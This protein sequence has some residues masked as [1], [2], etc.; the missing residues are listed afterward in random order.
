MLADIQLRDIADP[1][2]GRLRRIELPI[3]EVGRHD[4]WLVKRPDT[5]LQH[6]LDRTGRRLP[7]RVITAARHVQQAAL[8]QY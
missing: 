1:V 6:R 8:I 4:R 7:T 3:E 2:K 5:S